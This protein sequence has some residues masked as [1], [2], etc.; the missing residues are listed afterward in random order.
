MNNEEY[1]LLLSKFSHEIRNP[2]ALIN[3]F[4]QL[5]AHDYPQIASC[6]YYRKIMENMHLLRQLL[7]ELSHFNNADRIRVEPFD[8]IRLI[9][10]A[11]SSSRSVLNEKNIAFQLE[12]PASLPKLLI[13]PGKM[14]QVFYNLFRNA[15][16]AMPDGGL[17][18]VSADASETEQTIVIRV[19]DSGPSIPAEYLPTLFDPLIT[20]KKE[21]TGL[22]LSICR[23]ILNAHGGSITAAPDGSP[24]FTMILPYGSKTSGS[25]PEASPA[26]SSAASA[27]HPQGTLQ[28]VHSH[29]HLLSENRPRLTG[30]P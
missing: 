14:L 18:T 11:V 2:V 26:S 17:I 6:A 3:S 30:R 9:R 22:G 25:L 7:E 23:E 16:E 24:V 29:Q 10:E 28:D 5:L 13:D 20:H 8:M 4:L 1:R 15:E 27:P 21:G 12:L 19:K